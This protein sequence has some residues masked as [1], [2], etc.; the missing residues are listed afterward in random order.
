[1]YESLRI[2]FFT[3][4]SV[5]EKQIIPLIPLQI[6]YWMLVPEW[7]C[8]LASLTNCYYLFI[9]TDGVKQAK[10][11]T[12]TDLVLRDFHLLK[13]SWRKSLSH[14]S[15]V[16]WVLQ[17]FFSSFIFSSEPYPLPFPLLAHGGISYCPGFQVI[18]LFPFVYSSPVFSSF[19]LA[20]WY[21]NCPFVAE[22]Q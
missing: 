11:A 22:V 5:T 3:L 2:S 18:L 1:M 19:T 20:F 13:E 21:Q 7:K 8:Y 6:L 4:A 14:T 17:I 16:T 9:S 10:V 12:K 15:K